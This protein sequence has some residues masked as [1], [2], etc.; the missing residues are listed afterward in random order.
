MFPIGF[1]YPGPT[2]E[3]GCSH[4]DQWPLG[5]IPLTHIYMGSPQNMP[6]ELPQERPQ[7]DSCWMESI[8]A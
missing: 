4:N 8:T 6:S 7:T 1:L 5:V 2:S 3:P